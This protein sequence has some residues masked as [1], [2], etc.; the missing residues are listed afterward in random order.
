MHYVFL[1]IN[2]S[3]LPL[4]REYLAARKSKWYVGVANFLWNL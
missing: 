2:K 3:I 4:A 1:Q